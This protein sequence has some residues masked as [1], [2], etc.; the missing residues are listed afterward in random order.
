MDKEHYFCATKQSAKVG[1]SLDL[2]KFCYDKFKR[3]R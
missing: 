2:Y 1:F 3:K